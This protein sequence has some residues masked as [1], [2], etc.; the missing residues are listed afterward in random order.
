[1]GVTPIYSIPFAEP[2]DLVRDWPELSEDV[3]DAVEAAIAG[4]PVLAGIGSNVVSVTKADPFTTTSTSF[5][6]VD[7]LAATITPTAAT[8]KVLVI[9]QMYMRDGSNTRTIN[10]R[11]MRGSTA[12][13]IGD[14]AGSRER[15]T[16]AFVH[17]GAGTHH[18]FAMNAAFLD[19]PGVDTATTYS[20]QIGSSSAST[21][22][23]NSS[24]TD[25]DEGR[26][27]RTT[28]SITLIEVAA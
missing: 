9:V 15:A 21:Y 1:M 27:T 14:A 8:S 6:A 11:L 26:A 10:F 7:G 24:F 2:T 28:S 23:V 13:S 25:A 16:G 18:T 20:V 4:V 12:I 22:A 5:V 3:A 19:S 17:T